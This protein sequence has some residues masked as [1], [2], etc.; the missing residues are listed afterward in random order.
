MKTKKVTEYVKREY[1]VCRN[2]DH[3]HRSRVVSENCIAQPV[4]RTGA[5]DATIFKAVVG[6]RTLRSVAEE[7]A[8][9]WEQRR[10]DRADPS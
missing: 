6:G 5:R 4:S 9:L 10:A 3:R 1:W 8:E 7:H 2:A